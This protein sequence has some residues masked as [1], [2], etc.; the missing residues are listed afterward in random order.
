MT[1]VDEAL[2]ALDTICAE[3][4]SFVAAKGYVS[5]ADTRAKIIDRI[6]REV[7][8][9]P[10]GAL[11]RED[12]V[13]RGFIDYTLQARGKAHIVVEAKRAGLPFTFP[14]Y[15]SHRSLSLKGALITDAETREAIDQV[16]GY[17]DDAGV[18]YAIATNGFA[19]VVFR[20]VRDD[21]SWRD[22]KARIF[23]GLDSVREKF[24]EFW[25]LLSFPAVTA[26][27]LDREFA[28]AANA[29]R[30]LHR[31]T[32]KLFNAD[33]PLQR[34][35]L[36]GQIQPLIR[37]VFEDI[38]DQDQLEILQS[39]YVHSASLR[40][41]AQDL[42][43]I[44]S[45]AVPRFLVQEGTQQVTQSR[46]DAGNF[47]TALSKSIAFRKGQLFLILGGI[48]SGKTTFLKRYQRTVGREILD[49]YTLAFHVD[50]L[51]A[52]LEG[53]AMERFV[54]TSILD[55]FRQRNDSRRHEQWR[56]LKDV[57]RDKLDALPRPPRTNLSDAKISE[58]LAAWQQDVVDY[59]PRLLRTI[60]ASKNCA[61]V[62]F[63]DNVDQL[64]PS[65][66]AQIFMLAQR[67]TRVIDST[68]VVALREE[69]YYT[70]DIQKTF[71]AYTA[72]K[73]HIASP[74]FRTLIRSRIEF[75]LKLVT[76]TTAA[77][78][79]QLQMNP[80][81]WQESDSITRF[82]LIVQES[83]FVRNKR[84]AEFVEAVCFGNMR[85]A[86]QM[87]A[88]FLT[89]GV[90]DVGKMLFIHSRQ[91]AYYVA[92][93]EFLKSIML[94]DR[95]YYKSAHSPILNVFE[96]GTERNSS[97]FTS[98]RILDSLLDHFSEEAAPGRG[99]VEISRM[100]L[101]F[102]DVF[103]NAD[104][105]LTTLTRLVQRQLVEVNTRSTETI[106]GA[107]HVRATSS[108]WY[109]VRQLITSFA[110]LDLVL[111]DTPFSNAG[112]ESELR[113]KVSL[114]DNLGDKDEDKLDRL[115]VRFDRVELF[116]E[117]LEKEEDAEV[118]GFGLER[119]TDS[120][121][122]RYVPAIRGSFQKQ[123][124]WIV[125]RMSQNREETLW[126]VDVGNESGDGAPSV[127][128]APADESEDAAG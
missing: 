89:S 104:D 119:R 54:W 71:S 22:G 26:G 46:H 31:V 125:E 12:H 34:N 7:L 96:C 24:T 51:K 15:P 88:T 56:A 17:C 58:H 109:Y 40:I 114:V 127:L 35:R 36:H 66:Q 68:T 3:F 116:L 39:C 38:A 92:F 14:K 63:I 6:L 120:L 52:P 23:P 1:N 73:F 37:T 28:S 124:D 62:L 64:A 8:L 75:A 10:E 67:V 83:I 41:I 11:S 21:M 53:A 80:G 30:E 93:H 97:H 55:S 99:Y 32:D 112:T 122:T 113:R 85:M 70:A 118:R 18:R 90:T 101:Q 5:E 111:Q 61:I 81:P 94:G 123:K 76:G 65:Y 60:A 19:W 91:G 72:Q 117:Y 77:P 9:W 44:I 86:L 128:L 103:D 69:S 4:S 84:I 45:D 43:A 108:G 13:E 100:L 29:S 79:V 27:S 16:R 33:V 106:A 121:A 110:Y 126:E 50:F 74:R 95:R 48:G 102:E 98:A 82:L 107:T 42:D 49:K 20:A 78:A 115:K 2:A 47:G 57:F 25:N 105:V 59:T 87:F